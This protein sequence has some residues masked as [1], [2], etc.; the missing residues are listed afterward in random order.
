MM[1]GPAR[2]TWVLAVSALVLLSIGYSADAKERSAFKAKE[3]RAEPTAPQT[4]SDAAKLPTN[5]ESAAVTAAGKPVSV[6]PVAPVDSSMVTPAMTAGPASGERIPWQVLSGGGGKSGAAAYL[7]SVTIGQTAVGM[8]S[9][10]NYSLNQGFWQVFSVGGCCVG[11]TGNVDGDPGDLTDISD[12]SA[13][14]DYLFFGGAISSCFA[15][16]DVDGSASVDISD[17]Q[18]LIDFLFFGAALPNCL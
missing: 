18:A 12:L 8:T 15:E 4:K 1:P 11:S 13:M 2:R 17:L 6:A 14:V 10:P 3:R 7:M 5:A 16:S 9:S